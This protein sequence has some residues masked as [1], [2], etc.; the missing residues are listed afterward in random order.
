MSPELLENKVRYKNILSIVGS[1][2]W[3]LFMST[4]IRRKNPI[5][6]AYW[7][8]LLLGLMGVFYILFN[9]ELIGIESRFWIVGLTGGLLLSLLVSPVL[10]ELIHSIIFKIFGAKKIKFNWN[11]GLFRFKIQA[12]DFVM[13]KKKY[14]LTCSL[15]FFLFSILPFAVAFYVDG[16]LLFTLLALSFFHALYAMRDLAVCSYLY[17]FSNCYMY[18]TEENKTVFYKSVP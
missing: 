8:Y 14:Y 13:S 2:E 12:N 7:G 4:F 18:S 9:Y 17:K 5:T 15:T 11:W 1:S 16:I 3:L 6:I 10:H